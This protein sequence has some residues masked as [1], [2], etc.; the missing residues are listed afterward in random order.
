[1]VRIDSTGEADGSVVTVLEDTLG[2]VGV[3]DS[4]NEPVEDEL[5]E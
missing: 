2:I 3:R 1:M 4:D 5:L